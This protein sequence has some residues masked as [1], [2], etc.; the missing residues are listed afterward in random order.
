MKV[1]EGFDV[2][3]VGT[4]DGRRRLVYR[5]PRGIC[6]WVIGAR[7]R[8][9]WEVEINILTNRIGWIELSESTVPSHVMNLSASA[10]RLLDKFAREK[11]NHVPLILVIFAG[12]VTWT[13]SEPDM[14]V[15]AI[16][17]D[18]F[19]LHVIL[20]YDTIILFSEGE[21]IESERT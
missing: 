20:V 1:S 6:R 9:S 10:A 13:L 11:R 12:F 18:A 16:I 3:G 17:F 2:V 15:E 7:R 19:V 14:Y 5:R 8:L 21:A 4:T